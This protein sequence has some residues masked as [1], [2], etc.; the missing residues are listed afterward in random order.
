MRE[1][2]AVVAAA[3]EYGFV[4]PESFVSVHGSAEVAVAG[5][6]GSETVVGCAELDSVE[7]FGTDNTEPR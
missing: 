7:P 4:G 2:A 3:F 6:I 1:L 5:S